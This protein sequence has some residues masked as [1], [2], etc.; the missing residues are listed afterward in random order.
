MLQMTENKLKQLL[1]DRLKSPLPGEKAQMMMAAS[2]RKTGQ[3][4][5]EKNISPRLSSVMIL[6]YFA[7][8]EWKFP[9]IKRPEYNGV[10]SG[11]MALPGGRMEDNDADRINTA[12]RET[13]EET[14]ADLRK[15]EILGQLTELKIR[16]SGNSVLPVIGCL[17]E[18][19]VFRPDPVEVDSLHTVSIDYLLNDEN[20][21]ITKIKIS[22]QYRVEAPYFDVDGQVVWGATAMILSEFLYIVR[23]LTGN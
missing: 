21:K 15:V 13:E 12:I 11:Q 16:A 14:G 8:N 4:N 6:L 1:Y 9:L 17:P 2:S 7:N 18:I 23:E 20:R 19:P 3:Y 5:M 22:E 10:H